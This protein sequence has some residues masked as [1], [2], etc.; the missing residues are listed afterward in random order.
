MRRD[1]PC[2]HRRAEDYRCFWDPTPHK[3][4]GARVHVK[5]SFARQFTSVVVAEV[6]RRG[7]HATLVCSCPVG[8]LHIHNTHLDHA[9]ARGRREDM[10]CLA[11]WVRRHPTAHHIWGGGMN[12]VSE[13]ADRTAPAQPLA[14]DD[15][16]GAIGWKL[17]S[18]RWRTGPGLG[19]HGRGST[20]T[21]RPSRS[22]IG[23][24]SRRRSAPTATVT[25]WARCRTTAR[26][27]PLGSR[28]RPRSA[29]RVGCRSGSTRRPSGPTRCWPSGGG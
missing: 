5:A 2:R 1:A 3:A 26:C 12:F 23:Q 11:R 20:G 10:R 7:R 28:R 14:G 6:G 29:F 27:A 22:G 9:T 18:P 21:T 13:A 4:K 24:A 17:S 19:E 25:P 8:T 15:P 16:S